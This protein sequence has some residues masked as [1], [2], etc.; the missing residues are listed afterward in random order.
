MA[1]KKKSGKKARLRDLP[2]SGKGQGE[3]TAEQARNVKGG[4]DI[5]SFQWGAS[6]PSSSTKQ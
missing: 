3:L 1:S 2:Q 4:I 6:N 5:K